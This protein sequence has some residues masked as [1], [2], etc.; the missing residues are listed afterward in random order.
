MNSDFLQSFVESLDTSLQVKNIR[1]YNSFLYNSLINAST[2]PEF[3]KM[4]FYINK[5]LDM[6]INSNLPPIYINVQNVYMES[7]NTINVPKKSGCPITTIPGVLSTS[8]IDNVFISDIY[9]NKL[10]TFMSTPSNT[11]LIH[12]VGSTNFTITNIHVNSVFMNVGS[13]IFIQFVT[14]LFTINKQREIIDN[15]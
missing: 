12:I 9:I 1:V 14:N 7:I 8:Y 4:F 5:H 6:L 13:V 11:G 15:V 3:L 10:T 2:T